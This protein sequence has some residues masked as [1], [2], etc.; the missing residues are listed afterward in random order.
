MIRQRAA[1]AT[2]EVGRVIIAMGATFMR[3]AISGEDCASGLYS[4]T[5]QPRLVTPILHHWRNCKSRRCRHRG[6]VIH[7]G[8]RDAGNVSSGRRAPSVLCASVRGFPQELPEFRG[9][10]ST[11]WHHSRQC[12]CLQMRPGWGVD[13]RRR[14]WC[15]SPLGPS[16]MNIYGTRSVASGGADVVRRGVVVGDVRSRAVASDPPP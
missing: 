11:T 2:E 6:G 7:E 8:G 9:E 10:H 16:I 4:A 1:R 12:S 14:C 5:N 3:V 13:Q 15:S